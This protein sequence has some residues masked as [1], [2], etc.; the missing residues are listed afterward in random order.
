MDCYRPVQ[1]MS[2]FTILETVCRGGVTEMY[3][4]PLHVLYALARV[5]PIEQSRNMRFSEVK[6]RKSKHRK[7]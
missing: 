2:Y 3:S 7:S 1:L 5:F 4:Y 6:G